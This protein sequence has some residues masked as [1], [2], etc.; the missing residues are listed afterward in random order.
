M[1][2]NAT[3]LCAVAA[4]PLLLWPIASLDA[5]APTAPV[6]N[7]TASVIDPDPSGTNVR[8]TPGGD[9][10]AT[11][12]TPREG[13]DW[14]EVHLVGQAGD[15]FAIDRADLVGDARRTIF[16]G[17]GYMHHSVLGADGLVNGE[18]IRSAPDVDSPQILASEEGDQQAHLL[19]CWG[20]FMK[21]RVK[22]GVGW[23]KSLCLNQRTTCA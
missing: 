9:V 16:R 22:G 15:W 5:A 3:R 11:L 4:A 1:F 7:V 21:I 13:D 12:R 2:E 6:C 20:D 19:A 8:K 18:P 14:I 10:A 17:K 23:T